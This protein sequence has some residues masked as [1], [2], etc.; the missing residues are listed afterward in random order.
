MGCEV[1][2]Y[3]DRASELSDALRDLAD[4]G[5][6]NTTDTG[7]CILFGILRDCAYQIQ[8]GLERQGNAL[9][10]IVKSEPR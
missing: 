7:C 2:D 4:A 8:R 3:V 6:A 9:R 1:G 5:E 10:P